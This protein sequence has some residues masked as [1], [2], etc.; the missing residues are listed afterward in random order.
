MNKKISKKEA[1]EKVDNFFSELKNK[2]TESIM[3]MKRLAMHHH[4]S[5]NKY[6]RL[7]CRKC[8]SIF[9]SK[10]S[11]MRI[12]KLSKIILCKNCGYRSVFRMNLKLS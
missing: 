9:D 3:K 2:D 12:K 4:I 8:L 10:N 11:N 5:L 6:K 1:K 7:Y